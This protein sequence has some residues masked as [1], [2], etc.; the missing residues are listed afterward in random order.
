M[1]DTPPSITTPSPAVP[2]NINIVAVASAV[3][4]ALVSFG[5]PIS[6]DQKASLLA[7]VAIC[8]PLII[9]AIHTFINHPATVQKTL[10]YARSLEVKTRKKAGLILVLFLAVSAMSGCATLNPTTTTTAV[11]TLNATQVA[12]NSALAIYD[13][14][15]GANADAAVCSAADQAMAAT[16][17][18]AVA[19][20]IQLAQT[21][22]K[23]NS[24]QTLTSDQVTASLAQ[25]QDAVGN[26]TTSSTSSRPPRRRAQRQRRRRHDQI[27]DR[28]GRP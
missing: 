18:K 6:D 21:A 11:N 13:A 27:Q 22:L 16:L 7:L 25:V 9:A 23:A 20:S 26:F 2:Q 5:L 1:P 3:M 12:F 8:A 17:E 28:C 10:D 15:C 14:Y 19:D 4:V 24:T